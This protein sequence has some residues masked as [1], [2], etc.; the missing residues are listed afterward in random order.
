VPLASDCTSRCLM[1]TM[2]GACSGQ[3]AHVQDNLRP[4]RGY[5]PST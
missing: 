5:V 4:A 2:G 1:G 3:P